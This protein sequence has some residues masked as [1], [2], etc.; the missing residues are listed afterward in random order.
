MGPVSVAGLKADKYLRITTGKLPEADFAYLDE[1]FKASLAILNTLLR[2]LNERTFDAGD[3]VARKVP[4]KLCVAASN[5]WP[6]AETGK[7]LGA[8][9]DRFVLRRSVRPIATQAGRS[10][11]LWDA[12]LT[13]DLSTTVTPVELE[14]AAYEASGMPWSAAG[15]EAME[16]ILRDLA[17]EGVQP[18]DRRQVKAVKVAR[19]FAWLSGAAEVQPDHWPRF[20][21]MTRRNSRRPAPASLPRLP[22]RSAC[23]STPRFWKPSRFSRR[24]IAGSSNRP[25]RPRR[26]SPKLTAAF[27]LSAAGTAGRSRRGPTCN[28]N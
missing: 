22:T 16:T 26:N 27:L 13:P 21:G 18:G 12:D 23:G 11:L 25:L 17:K 6:S 9:F 8:L 28:R 1:I 19:A 7:E 10:R 15:R 5:E 4:L 3:G 2:I 24:P 14:A 20:S